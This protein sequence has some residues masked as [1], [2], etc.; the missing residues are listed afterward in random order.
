MFSYM[1]ILEIC[2]RIMSKE[3]AQAKPKGPEKQNV[4]KQN[5][6]TSILLRKKKRCFVYKKIMNEKN[7]TLLYWRFKH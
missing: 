4:E 7:T 1:T 5:L 6:T 3:Y 2:S